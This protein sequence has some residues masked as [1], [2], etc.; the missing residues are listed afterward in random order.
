M[1]IV[2]QR[3]Y[4]VERAYCLIVSTFLILNVKPISDE[5]FDSE[6]IQFLIFLAGQTDSSLYRVSQKRYPLLA[7]NRNEA[8]R[9]HYSPNGQ[10][11]LLLFSKES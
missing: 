9:Y 7:G 11:S 4:V 5:I 6:A 8:I 1:K 10:L 3:R 2:L